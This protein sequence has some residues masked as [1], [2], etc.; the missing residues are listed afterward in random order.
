MRLLSES[1]YRS[2]AEPALSK[3]FMSDNPREQHFGVN[4]EARKLIY[5]YLA[6]AEELISAI[7]KSASK[8]GD[9]GFYLSI[10]VRDNSSSSEQSCHWWVPFDETQ[11]YLSGNTD[12]FRFAYQLEHVI[13]SPNGL[14]GIMGAFE[15][16]GILTGKAEIIDEVS[17]AI[18]EVD[19]QV[20]EYLEYICECIEIWGI[21]NVNI[22]WLPVLLERIYGQYLSSQM[23]EKINTFK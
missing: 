21:G 3:V 16:F 23:L 15:N 17:R 19:K 18:P 20:Y 7:V 13:Y 10:L 5:E 11:S 14:W 1:D 9:D 6:P 4:A 8:F 22:T 2:E 12:I